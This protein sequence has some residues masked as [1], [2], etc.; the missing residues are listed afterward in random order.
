MGQYFTRYLGNGVTLRGRLND[1]G[2]YETATYERQVLIYDD[3]LPED[4]EGYLALA[5]RLR[6]LPA[7]IRAQLVIENPAEDSSFLRIYYWRSETEAEAA[8][9]AANEKRRRYET[10]KKKYEA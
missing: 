7:E 8:E 9:R 1:L 2:L 6:E 10:L 4:V 5:D 3:F